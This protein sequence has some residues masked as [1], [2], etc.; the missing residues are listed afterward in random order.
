[1][2]SFETVVTDAFEKQ[3]VFAC[4]IEFDGMVLGGDV[5]IEFSG[6]EESCLL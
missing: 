4:G 1:M 6:V 2:E 5:E 3:R